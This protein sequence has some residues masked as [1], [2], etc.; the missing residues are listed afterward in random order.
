MDKVWELFNQALA[1]LIPV[2][3]QRTYLKRR[4]A[5]LLNNPGL[6]LPD[7]PILY[8]F[9]HGTGKT[10]LAEILLELTKPFSISISNSELVT[11]KFNAV[12]ENKLFIHLS[13]DLNLK[14][15]N[16]YTAFKA[17]TGDNKI[18]IQRKHCEA[19]QIDNYANLFVTCNDVDRLIL[20]QDE[21]RIVILDVGQISKPTVRALSKARKE[22]P[23]FYFILFAKFK[24]LYDKE[25][26]GNLEHDEWGDRLPQGEMQG[27][28]KQETNYPTN[29]LKWLICF[30][31]LYNLASKHPEVFTD[32][33][34]A[35][36]EGLKEQ[37]LTVFYLTRAQI[38]KSF[39]VFL[40][41]ENQAHHK[42][43]KGE[44]MK[45][46]CR[47]DPAFKE[48]KVKREG[49]ILKRVYTVDLVK[50]NALLEGL[51]ESK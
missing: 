9:E 20:V 27:A 15:K 2:S 3:D 18:P 6:K 44:L 38:W 21:R 51:T 41:S 31:H 32:L 40:E 5:H 23:Y 11:G 42:I 7:V 26:L 17:L 50:L 48:S 28:K 19:Y 13:E 36:L 22:N 35:D 34:R 24:E 37:H 29:Y 46:L 49:N 4:I 45:G 8:S 43:N 25:G 47:I 30:E 16:A 10:L 39:K 33:T 1:E 14:E 12:I